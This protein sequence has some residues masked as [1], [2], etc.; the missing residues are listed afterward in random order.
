MS[1][2]KERYSSGGR[3]MSVEEAERVTWDG[4]VVFACSVVVCLES[5]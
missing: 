3:R 2:R 4:T 5:V 1:D